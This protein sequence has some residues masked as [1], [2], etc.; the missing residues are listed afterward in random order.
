MRLLPPAQQ[1]A[2]LSDVEEFLRDN[3]VLRVKDFSVEIIDGRDEGMFSWLTLNY[4]LGRLD[5][6]PN[7]TTR[8]YDNVSTVEHG[9]TVATVDMGGASSQVVFEL[10]KKDGAWL[11]F[12]YF[13]PLKVYQSVSKNG[14]RRRRRPIYLYQHSYLGLGL[15]EARKR[16]LQQLEEVKESAAKD[17]CF[18]SRA[19]EEKVKACT[20]L[21]VR[22]VLQSRDESVEDPK[23]SCTHRSCGMQAVPQPVI[24]SDRM[25]VYVFSFFTD[26]IDRYCGDMCSKSTEFTVRTIDDG[27]T[28]MKVVPV[29]VYRRMAEKLCTETVYSL[30]D[31]LSASGDTPTTC[32]DVVYL[33]AY[34]SFGLEMKDTA[35]VYVPEMVNGFS[36]AW[37]LG[38]SLMQVNEMLDPTVE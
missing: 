9:S 25:E 32:L 37:P 35:L 14:N 8:F 20:A 4:I 16:L 22:H 28:N 18:A 5:L 1:G 17:P 38:A 23:K 34:L 13:T 15:N 10:D 7:T 12:T 27:K 6:S 3:T 30:E 33:Y 31:Y 19:G 24:Q 21:F 26:M 2:I 36:V 29:S 11:P